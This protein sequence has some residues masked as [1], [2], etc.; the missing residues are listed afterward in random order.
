[1]K[2]ARILLYEGVER[3]DEYVIAGCEETEANAFAF[4]ASSA[5]FSHLKHDIEKESH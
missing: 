5:D 3:T 2:P 4:A 1:M